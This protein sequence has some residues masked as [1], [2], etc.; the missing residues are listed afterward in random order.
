MPRKPRLRLP[1]SVLKLDDFGRD[2]RNPA[3]AGAPPGEKLD[4]C[5]DLIVVAQ[6]WK[7]EQLAF[8]ICQP[9]RVVRQEQI[10]GFN[11]MGLRRKSRGLIRI[12]FSEN[13]RWNACRRP[14]QKNSA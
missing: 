3:S 12:R 10:A 8:E 11:A 1:R 14:C 6:V 9:G 5:I 7:T 4:Q 13:R 2:Q